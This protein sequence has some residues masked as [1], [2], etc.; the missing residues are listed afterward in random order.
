[1]AILPAIRAAQSPR[2]WPTPI[3]R[4]SRFR[5][6]SRR[7]PAIFPADVSNPSAVHVNVGVQRELAPGMVLSADIVYRRFLDVPQNGGSIDVNHFN[8]VRGPVIRACVAAEA[9]DPARLVLTRSDQR[10][11]RAVSFHLQGA[12]ASRREAVLQWMADAR[13]V[14]VFEERR[15]QCRQRVQP[16]QLAQNTGPVPSDFTHVV[17]VAGVTRLPW[18][19]DLGLNFSYSSA[20]P[21]SAFIGGIDLNGDGTPPAAVRPATCCRA[22]R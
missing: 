16:R 5:S 6:P 21:F 22:R 13:L 8:S 20:P 15:H 14:C 11:R 10:L 2:A 9:T 19:V 1:M 18:R 7:V 17:N 3:R 4:C 12:A